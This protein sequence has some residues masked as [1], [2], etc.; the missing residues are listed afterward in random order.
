MDR[1]PTELQCRIARSLDPADT[2][3]LMR[4]GSRQLHDIG[5]E[6]LYGSLQL[7][8]TAHHPH[9]LQSTS[10]RVHGRDMLEYLSRDSSHARLGHPAQWLRH[11]SI[12]WPVFSSSGDERL[13]NQ[14]ISAL[15][16]A[17]SLLSLELKGRPPSGWERHIQEY[18]SNR[19]FLPRLVAINTATA[20]DAISLTHQRRMESIFIDTTYLTSPD[21]RALLDAA[22]HSAPYM[23]KLQ[24]SLAMDSLQDVLATFRCIAA[25]L[26]RLTVLC[27]EI[28][29]GQDFPERPLQWTTLKASGNHTS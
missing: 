8:L 5:G 25:A 21:F 15:S 29:L 14:L 22:R 18:A 2:S 23:K 20:Q 16:H 27:V 13:V 10:P 4:V 6:H 19:D 1:L 24:V 12:S 26:P 7:R 9:H 3:R 11:L 28:D 17:G